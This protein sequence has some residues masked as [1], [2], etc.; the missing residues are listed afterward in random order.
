MVSVNDLKTIELEL[1]AP[2]MSPLHRA[3][4]GGLA[5]T[6]HAWQKG[7]CSG[8]GTNWDYPFRFEIK[9]DS[10]TLELSE[11]QQ[12]A[13]ALQKLFEFGFQ[14]NSDGLIFLPGQFHSPPDSALLADLQAG[15]LLTFLQHGTSRKLAKNESQVCHRLSGGGSWEVPVAYRKW[16]WFK[17]QSGWKDLIDQHGRFQTQPIRIDSSI[18]PGASIR[19][20]AFKNQTAIKE[21]LKRILPLYFSLVGCLAMAVNRGV[22]ILLVPEVKDLHEFIQQRPRLNPQHASECRVLNSADAILQA[23]MRVGAKLGINSVT[24]Q[25]TP[26]A[27]Q[28]KSRVKT[29]EVGTLD[30]LTI[31]HF[32]KVYDALRPRIV[33]LESDLNR[34]SSKQTT[35]KAFQSGYRVDSIMRSLIAENLIARKPWY[36]G[37]SSMMSKTNPNTGR[38]FRDQVMY[39]AQGLHQL[40]STPGIWGRDEERLL[41]GMIQNAVTGLLS[42]KRSEAIH[43]ARRSAPSTC[44]WAYEKIRLKLARTQCQSQLRS[45][46]SQLLNQSS[47]KK[48]LSTE[49]NQCLAFINE[50]WQRC[51]DLSLLALVC[52]S[53]R[54]SEEQKLKQSA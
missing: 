38:L 46:L 23:K 13:N 17:Q 49:Y 8:A 52:F 51:R 3:G 50:D 39:E 16:S 45:L 47:S 6:L 54:V 36:S 1:H 41:V 35:V 32:Q 4:L 27:L 18:Y 30:D 22:G 40:I 10:I 2:G 24:F 34:S 43:S 20:F 53:G 5:C 29:C 25:P 44:G 7:M 21:P 26:W 28:I 33:A 11:P 15:Y 48:T 37:F 9:T 14:I 19:H 12:A 31:S 42:G